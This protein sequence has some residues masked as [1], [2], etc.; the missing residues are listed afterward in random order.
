[1]RSRRFQ[2]KPPG[3][4]AT[5]L[6]ALDGKDPRFDALGSRSSP[7]NRKALQLAAQVERTLVQVFGGECAD[8]VLCDLRVESVAPAPD[9]A[10]LL[11]V[12]SPGG[13]SPALEIILEHLARAN[14]RL[15]SEV[16]A[17]IHRKKAPELHFQ[18]TSRQ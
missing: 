6:G 12:L 10:H 17:A 18:I 11:V 2:Q 1:M 4:L 15:R 14:G 7:V 9:S 13:D 16:A 5:E 8:E 3:E